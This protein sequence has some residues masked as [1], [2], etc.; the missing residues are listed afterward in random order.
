MTRRPTLSITRVPQVKSRLAIAR[1]MQVICGVSLG[2]LGVPAHAGAPTAKIVGIG[3]V[4]CDF[5]TQEITS[6]PARLRD[7]VAWA[8]GFMSG[9]LI[10]APEGEDLSIDL[11]PPTFPLQRQAAF[12]KDFCA[13]RGDRAFTDAVIELYRTLRDPRS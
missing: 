2:T 5:F 4:P 3:A 12:L 6:D 1:A 10:R 8:Q 13:N 7:Y 9:A 11:L